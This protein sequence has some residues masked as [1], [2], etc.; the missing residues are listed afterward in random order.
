MIP[1][2]YINA[3]RQHAPWQEE[4]QVEQDLILERA[5][6]EIFSDEFLRTKVAFRGGTAL[7]KI[8][9][10]PQARYSEDIDLVQIKAEPISATLGAL[11]EKLNF[12]G[13]PVVKQK[14]HNNTLLF[15]FKSE[16]GIPMKLKV[17]MNCREHISVFGLK[18]VP[19]KVESDWFSGKAN[20]VTYTTEELLG[21]KLRALYQRKKGRD[22]FDMWC[23]ITQTDSAPAKIIEAF[24]AYLKNEKRII[25]RKQFI[26]NMELKM[27]EKDFLD[28]MKWVLRLG[29][30]FDPA[31]A[32]AKVR[33]TILE[34]L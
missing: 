24:R 20:I 18:N 30:D 9:L 17:E 11:R 4:T 27:K 29:V 7:H 16:M 25:T 15:R 1:Q 14:K 2:A 34:N 8:Y 13:N 3:W 28:D 6:I 31:T 5:I 12:L 21:T 33:E 26:Q 10:R 22:L 19:F 23:G 32:Y